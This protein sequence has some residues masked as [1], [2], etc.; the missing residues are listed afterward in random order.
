MPLNCFM[1]FNLIKKEKEFMYSLRKSNIYI[2]LTMTEDSHNITSYVWYLHT[3]E[4]VTGAEYVIGLSNRFNKCTNQTVI[5]WNNHHTFERT[6]CQ[7]H[8]WFID[9]PHH[10]ILQFHKASKHYV[11]LASLWCTTDVW[12]D[13]RNNTRHFDLMITLHLQT[14][15]CLDFWNS[16]L[17][18]YHTQ[19]I[20]WS[21]L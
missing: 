11:C 12:C 9:L 10:H 6:E 18:N 14:Q 20:S 1:L 3:D 15:Y 8:Q 17:F 4:P 5:M 7:L 2:K 13:C 19:D 21:C 16:L